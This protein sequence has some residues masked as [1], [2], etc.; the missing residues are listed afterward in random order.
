[1]KARSEIFERLIEDVR[2]YA[3]DD[4]VPQMGSWPDLV[5]DWTICDIF[6]I[7]AFALGGI[8]CGKK[9]WQEVF[10]GHYAGTPKGRRLIL[11][12][13]ISTAYLMNYLLGILAGIGATRERAHFL[14]K[15]NALINKHRRMTVQELY[16]FVSERWIKAQEK[17]GD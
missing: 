16:D 17:K 1:M 4:R 12:K 14:D 6:L 13:L 7:M 8:S 11:E 15:Q 10:A 5:T 3:N 2:V 9:D